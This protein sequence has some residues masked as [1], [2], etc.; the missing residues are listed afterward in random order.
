MRIVVSRH[1]AKEISNEFIYHRIIYTF[2]NELFHCVVRNF[3]TFHQ[4]YIEKRIWE[5][6]RNLFTRY[7]FRKDDQ[8]SWT[9]DLFTALISNNVQRDRMHNKTKYTQ[10]YNKRLMTDWFEIFLLQLR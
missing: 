6:C 1:G 2:F 10:V 7:P 5:L 9:I 8:L 4:H 3:L